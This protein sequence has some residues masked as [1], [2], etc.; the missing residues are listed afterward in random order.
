MR[1]PRTAT[2]SSP[3]L[4][5]LEK[6]RVQHQRS[7][8]AKNKFIKKQKT[9][10]DLN[11]PK[12]APQSCS[13]SGPGGPGALAR[14][15]RRSCRARPPQVSGVALPAPSLPALIYRLGEVMAPVAPP[16]RPQ[17]PSRAAPRATCVPSSEPLGAQGMT[18]P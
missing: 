9:M 12:I 1:S 10:N 11:R 16:Y 8:A 7:N 17:T 14:S 13:G 6:A 18:L 3:C 15:P 5:Q 2:K 4:P